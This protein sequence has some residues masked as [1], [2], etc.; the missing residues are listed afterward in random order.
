MIRIV[1]EGEGGCGQAFEEDV[2][3]SLSYRD[4]MK[5]VRRA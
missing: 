1:R 5:G 2:G 4:D 3:I